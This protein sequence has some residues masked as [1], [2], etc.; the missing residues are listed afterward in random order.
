M[1]LQSAGNTEDTYRLFKGY[2]AYTASESQF[3]HSNF[4]FVFFFAKTVLLDN[5]PAVEGT[6]ILSPHFPLNIHFSHILQKEDKCLI[7][8]HSYS[9]KKPAGVLNKGEF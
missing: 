4:A 1:S 9:V 5:V 3:P 2:S 7:H 6:W 8:P